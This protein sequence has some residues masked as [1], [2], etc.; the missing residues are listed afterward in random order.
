MQLPMSVRKS[1]AQL[2]LFS[3][4]GFIARERQV[5][6]SHNSQT[7][8]WHTHFRRAR[9]PGIL[10]APVRDWTIKLFLPPQGRGQV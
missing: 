2:L 8:I 1:H 5:R 3:E 4:S 9:A 7:A 6:R 10:T